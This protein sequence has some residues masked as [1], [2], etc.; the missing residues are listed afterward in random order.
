VKKWLAEV[1]E[2]RLIGTLYLHSLVIL[3]N[4]PSL[5]HIINCLLL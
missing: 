4:L 5:D 2:D 3:A 1:R